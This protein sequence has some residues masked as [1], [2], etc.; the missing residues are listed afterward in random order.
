MVT[1][2]ARRRG[3]PGRSGRARLHA[4]GH[5]RN[6]PGSLRVSEPPVDPPVA[7]GTGVPS[8]PRW[9]HVRPDERPPENVKSILIA[10]MAGLVVSLLLTPSLIR[11]FSRQGFGQEI[12][13]DGPQTHLE[14][15][16]TPTMGGLAIILAMWVGYAVAV[17]VQV[18]TGSGG[19][20]A[21]GGCCCS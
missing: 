21:S 13:T 20:T 3:A 1:A 2:R 12:R 4:V 16:G 14:K 18:L 8:L 15:R 11:F 7:V 6:Q 5:G 19:P 17:L 10:A 9:T